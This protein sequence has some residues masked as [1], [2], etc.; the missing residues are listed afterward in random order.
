MTSES[1]LARSRYTTATPPPGTAAI[2]PQ[3][4]EPGL[5]TIAASASTQA[6]SIAAEYRHRADH[7]LTSLDMPRLSVILSLLVLAA[8]SPAR[9]QTLTLDALVSAPFP[10][11]LAASPTGALAWA[12]DSAGARN[13][14]VA[15]P[16]ADTARRL[17][18]YLAD[19]GQELSALAWLPGDTAVVY[20]RGGDPNGTG[21]I[22]NPALL[23]QG[24]HQ[25]VW[26]VGLH[27]ATPH[28]VGAGG[29]VAVSATGRIAFVE[30]GEIYSGADPLIHPRGRASAL[31]WSPDGA[32]LAFVSTRGD[33]A[34]VGVYDVA[35]KTL[36][37]LAPSVD[38]DA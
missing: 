18:A 38:N 9:A 20:V 21:E 30:K 17:T 28:R 35:A 29:A 27:D 13:V 7:T 22:P 1:P 6:I 32:R 2:R 23:P 5:A 11:A 36:Q 14:W 4:S 16:P 8:P 25:E 24:V 33:H 12:S 37:Y 34:F 26:V 10:T 19:D 31:R 15:M 3:T